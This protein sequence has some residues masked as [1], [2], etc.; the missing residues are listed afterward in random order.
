MGTKN[1]VLGFLSHATADDDDTNRSISA[2]RG[3]IERR[4]HL[5][6]G[7]G[8]VL[9]QDRVSIWWGDLWEETPEG[10]PGDAVFFLPVLTPQ[11]FDGEWCRRETEAFLARVERG[12]KTQ[13]LPVYLVRDPRFETPGTRKRHAL[14]QRLSEYPCFD[15]RAY[16]VEG[17]AAP[18]A[19]RE[20]DR[21]ARAIAEQVVQSEREQEVLAEV[22]P[23]SAPSVKGSLTDANITILHTRRRRPAA[24]QA[25]ALLEQAGA[26]AVSLSV[27]SDSGNEHHQKML[28]FYGGAGH[29]DAAELAGTIAKIVAPV[30]L[31]VPRQGSAEV[32]GTAFFLWIV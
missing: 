23:S 18:G 19:L 17:W 11:F 28:Y 20:I 2:L 12:A 6:G 31:V 14:R 29:P 25:L 5:H 32:E 13:I 16:L 7:T 9:L 15:L 22:G 24:K 8:F 21:M 1:E 4:V 26:N 3:V 27:T 30:E 10:A